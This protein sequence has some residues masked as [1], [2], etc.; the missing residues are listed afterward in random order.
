MYKKFYF[1]AA[2]L[3]MLAVALGAFGSHLLKTKLTATYMVTYQT[4]VQYQFYHVFAL[5]IAAQFMRK[6]NHSLLSTAAYCF[7]IGMC[8]FSFSL[9]G[10][11][12]NSL[13]LTDLDKSPTEVEKFLGYFTPFGG[14]LLIAGWLCLAIY[15]AKNRIVRKPKS[16][17][18][19][20]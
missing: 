18:S 9:Y 4:G 1:W 11:A 10:I 13:I 19:G 14:S 3:G 5:I 8:I 20:E 17:D 2:M 12:L 6:Y 15:F 16:N 7:L